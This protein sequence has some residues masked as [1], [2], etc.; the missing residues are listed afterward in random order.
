MPAEGTAIPWNAASPRQVPAPTHGMTGN[1]GIRN[2]ECSRLPRRRAR[3]AT[4]CASANVIRNTRLAAAPTWARSG[5]DS[6][7]TIT[8]AEVVTTA[9]VGARCR[10]LITSIQ[11][12]RFRSRAMAM[13]M[14]E[15]ASRFT[16][17]AVSIERI[18]AAMTS[19]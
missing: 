11:W 12:G 9:A 13:P 6:S 19:Q 1:P 8:R 18:P 4:R 16:R 3:M 5:T 17:S 15:A 2:A 7:T 10:G 14:R